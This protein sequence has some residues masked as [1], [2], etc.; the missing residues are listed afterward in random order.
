MPKSIRTG[1]FSQDR[2]ELLR[3][4]KLTKNIPT[5][6]SAIGQ[7]LLEIRSCASEYTDNRF[8]ILA[9]GWTAFHLSAL[10]TTFIKTLHLIFVISR[11]LFI[12]WKS[13]TSAV[14]SLVHHTSLL[15][16]KACWVWLFLFSDDSLDKS[17]TK[18]FGMNYLLLNVFLKFF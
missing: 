4:C 2:T 5:C 9:R 8:S 15:A 16:I 13:A 11:I 17:Q 1:Q 14:I 6:E 10:E 3:S 12:S 7:H 18:S